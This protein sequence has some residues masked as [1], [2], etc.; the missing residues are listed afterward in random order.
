[1]QENFLDMFYLCPVCGYVQ[2]P[3]PPRNF[4]ICPSCGTEFGFDDA[5]KSHAQ[6]RH[7]WIAREAPWFSRVRRPAPNWNPWQQLTEAGYLQFDVYQFGSNIARGETFIQQQLV[8]R[9][10]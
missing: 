9:P 8:V 4:S 2:L 5:K 10:A 1:M 7:E 6:L 3:E